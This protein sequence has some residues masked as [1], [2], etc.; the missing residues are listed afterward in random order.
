METSDPADVASRTRPSGPGDRSS[1]ACAA[2]IR[3]THVEKISPCSRKTDETLRREARNL[4]TDTWSA[5]TDDEYIPVFHHVFLA[6]QP[7]H[8]LVTNT[9]ISFVVHQVF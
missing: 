4:C 2:G 7:Q 9:G 3:H 5:V 1:F 6:F 8:S